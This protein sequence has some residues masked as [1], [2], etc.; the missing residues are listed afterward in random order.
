MGAG[1][2]YHLAK[3]G[4]SDVMLV[5]K[6]E[7]TSGSTWHAAA[8]IPHF[9]GNPGMARIHRY[10]TKMY[11][12]L[13]AETGQATGFHDCG[14]IRLGSTQD[15]HDWYLRVQAMLRSQGTECHI[16]GPDEISKLH[17]LMDLEGVK[18]GIYTPGDGHTDPAGSTNALAIGARARGA[19]ISLRNRVLEI[20]QCADNTWDVV[21][22]KGNINT[23]HV[24]NA[25]G[26]FAP[27]IG[28]MVGAKV[29]VVSI[30]HHYLVTENL[31][32][33]IALEK[34]PPTVRDPWASCYYRQEQNGLIIGPYEMEG[35][36]VWGLDGIDW[37]F[38]TEL[39]PP[40]LDILI[41]CL[42]AASKRLPSFANAGIK[43][44]VCGPITHV[45]D[46][47]ILI[48]PAT[49]FRNFW[50]CC[51]SS[52]GVTQGPG[53]GKYLAQ[54][55]VHG[56]AEIDVS[57]MDARRYG[58]WAVGSYSVEQSLEGYHDMFQVHLPSK[59][60][61]AGRPAR[62][63]PLHEKLK[64]RGAVF[65]D[66]HGWEVP[67]WFSLDGTE[68]KYSYR[69]T[70]WFDTVAE[71][72]RAVRERVGITDRTSLVKFEVSGKE[73]SRFLER[74]L[75]NRL[76]QKYG[77]ITTAQAVNELGGIECEFTITCLSENRYYLTAPATSQ[78]RSLD[79]M[80]RCVVEFDDAVVKD[81]TDEN[82]ALALA[83]PCARDVLARLTKEGLCNETF[84]V[85]SAREITIASI[86]V[87]ALRTS[88][89]GELGWEFHLK[90]GRL[91]ELY[92][93]LTAAGSTYQIADFGLYAADSLR[94]E[95][96][97]KMV[98][99]DYIAPQ[100]PVEAGLEHLTNTDSHFIGKDALLNQT[101]SGPEKRLVYLSVD[102]NDADCFGVEQVFAAGRAIGL[103][104][105]GAYGHTVKQSLAFAYIEAEFAKAGTELV[106]EI[107][108]Q[109]CSAKVLSGPAY[110]L[111]NL[112]VLGE[113]RTNDAHAGELGD[114]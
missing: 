5:E 26:S 14:T 62:A 3:E 66:R 42:E 39:L 111:Q 98:G 95:K 69:R 54:W 82:G 101:K 92:D 52:V 110:D 70:N 24:V 9:I 46:L 53:A 78:L 91:A 18:F 83:G 114:G 30:P 79:W 43:R 72:C 55:M 48:G 34:E 36:E 61:A 31:D 104:T 84:P 49:G 13:E 23:E 89:L 77:A 47:G 75:I 67:T 87:L 11:K 38:D 73:A 102:A 40:N 74:M 59:Q 60:C 17:P 20:N 85:A 15:E 63:A 22:E 96:A 27:Q 94:I 103:T 97:H 57:D 80:N 25:A 51:G 93:A 108:G 81:M 106:V 99:H 109:R 56:Q 21:T 12:E 16:I 50:L 112:K 105:S 100:T 88:G 90:M 6:G 28:A 45:P 37:S 2:L 68:E 107:L 10:A 44:T 1:L 7:L 33:V 32:E 8:F 19:E 76:P 86:P 64:A 4:W 58:D 65:V 29:P 35:A 71:E 113:K 41:P